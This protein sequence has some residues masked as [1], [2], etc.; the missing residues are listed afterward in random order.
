MKRFLF[1]LIILSSFAPSFASHIA[2]G[3]L[4]YTYLGP[5]TGN[6]DRY[7]ITMRL[8]RDC[9]SSGQQLGSETVTIGVYNS[10]SLS[11]QQ[12]VSL[13][14]EAPI[15]TI[16][17]NTNNIPCLLNPPVVCF[18][19]G[20]FSAE[21]EIPKSIT[22]YTLA[23][24]RCCRSDNIANLSVTTGVGA[25]YV[26]NIP[27]TTILPIGNNSSPKF[28]EKDAAL[29]CQGKNFELDF[30]ATDSDSD[31]LTFSFCNAYSG[32][33]SNAPN[34]GP[35]SV[36]ALNVLPYR[37]PY[38]GSLPLGAQ[39]SINTTTG[40]ITGIAPPTGRYVINVC[41]TEWR[42]GKPFNEHR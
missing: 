25:T 16:S 13:I 11:L 26:T 31:S 23:W 5:G 28:S 1:L 4:Y 6:N 3:E 41:I 36:L 30:S 40:K 32:G 20:K 17:L 27:G 24:L 18:E 9:F 33:S 2:G 21:V 15:T 34:P 10:L 7:K 42:D 19:V 22:G 35:A 14:L 29:V 37:S 12:S 39:V 38:S 8:L